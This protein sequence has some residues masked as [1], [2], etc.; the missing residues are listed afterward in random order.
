[1]NRVHLSNRMATLLMTVLAIALAAIPVQAQS[2]RATIRGY[3]DSTT[4]G[5]TTLRRKAWLRGL[6]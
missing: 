5:A 2:G 1:M 3:I 4:S 6:K